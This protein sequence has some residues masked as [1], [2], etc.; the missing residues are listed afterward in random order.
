M[1][2]DKLDDSLLSSINLP[3]SFL[4]VPFLVTISPSMYGILN[5]TSE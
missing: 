5:R 3:F 1:L 2:F 4:P